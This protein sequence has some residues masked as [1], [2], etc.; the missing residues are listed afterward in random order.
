MLRIGIDFDNTIVC[1]DQ[2]FRRVA[3][4]QG[5]IDKDGPTSKGAI[6]DY[7]RSVGKEDR[8]TAMQGYVYGER[9]IDAPAFPGVL[10]F[11]AGL[12]R[13]RIPVFIISHKT[14]RPYLGPSYDL[15]QSAQAW[16]E[17][18]GV[19]D[20]ARIG[21]SRQEVFFEL[22]KQAKL[23]RIAERDCSHFIDDLP[24]LLCEPT[25]PA[26]VARY[27]FDPGCEHPSDP[28]YRRLPTWHTYLHE[29]LQA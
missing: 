2:V 21:M 24:E 12:V 26:G 22:T 1:Y 5:L 4:E 14:R 9:M 3:L 15:H 25:F 7:L 11:L 29:L 10:D 8:W 6:R 20:P 18:Q 19:Y 23:E 28:R 17:K 13:K 16:L 27:L